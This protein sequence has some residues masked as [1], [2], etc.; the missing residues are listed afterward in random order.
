MRLGGEFGQRPLVLPN[1]DY[2]PDAFS[3]SRAGVAQLLARMQL[4]SGT[5]DI[6]IELE[7][8]DAEFE[9]AGGGCS[10][11]ACAVP[12]NADRPRLELVDDGWRLRLFTSEIHHPVGLTTILARALGA[13]FLEETRPDGAG[14]RQPFAVTQELAAVGLGFGVLLLEGSHVYAKSC[15]GPRISRLT[16]CSTG[17]LAVATALFAGANGHSLRKALSLV[18]ATQ[19][20]ALQAAR[21]L[22]EANAQLVR[23]FTQRPHTLEATDFA[24]NEPRPRLFSFF[25]SRPAAEDP[26]LEAALWDAAPLLGSPDSDQEPRALPAPAATTRTASVA[27]RRPADD[28]LAELVEASLAELRNG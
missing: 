22:F 27:Q 28:D 11:G 14:I 8:V 3:A 21:D 4:H 20:A 2:F 9:A 6:P 18:N 1:G 25:G 26:D 23:S 15:G 10:S 24:L 16:T 12:P 5:R 17:D 7:L 19:K 13:V